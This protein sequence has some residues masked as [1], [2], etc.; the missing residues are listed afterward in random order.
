MDGDFEKP[1]SKSIGFG[2]WF[3]QDP[4]TSFRISPGG[5]ERS[6]HRG[7]TGRGRGPRKTPPERL[8]NGSLAM[9][10]IS[11]ADSDARK[12]A[13]FRV[14]FLTIF[15]DSK[16]VFA[17]TSIEF[18]RERRRRGDPERP[19]SLSWSAAVFFQ[20]ACQTKSN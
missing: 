11:P 10:G 12:T 14:G 5:F 17:Y 1:F 6:P 3:V 16:T 15:L 4:W 18:D 8:K 9:L 20:S 13:Q 19:A 7:N 2:E